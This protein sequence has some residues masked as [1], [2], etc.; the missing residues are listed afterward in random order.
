MGLFSGAMVTFFSIPSF[1]A[2]L[3]MMLVASGL[4]FIAAQGQ[5][6]YQSAPPS[7]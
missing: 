6:I 1:I 7:T 4:A 2:T 3:A 5:S